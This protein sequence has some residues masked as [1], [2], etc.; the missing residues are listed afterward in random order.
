MIEKYRE[1]KHG[2]QPSEIIF[3]L[4][5]LFLIHTNVPNAVSRGSALQRSLAATTCHTGF[6]LTWK[7]IANG[8][9][10]NQANALWCRSMIE[11]ICWQLVHCILTVYYSTLCAMSSLTSWLLTKS[12]LTLHLQSWRC[13]FSKWSGLHLQ[14]AYKT[15]VCH[16]LN[17]ACRK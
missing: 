14:S 16:E 13:F 8:H 2:G 10:T 7:T 4:S 1:E 3:F 9:C 17:I 11:E 5:S 12:S 6:Y 15:R